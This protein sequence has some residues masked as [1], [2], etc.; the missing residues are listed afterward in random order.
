MEAGYLA[1]TIELIASWGDTEREAAR[2]CKIARRM[3]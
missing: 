1:A 3:R 2:A